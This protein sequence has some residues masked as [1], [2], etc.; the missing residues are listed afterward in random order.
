MNLTTFASRHRDQ[1]PLVVRVTKGYCGL[2]E[3][4]SISEGDTFNIHFVKHT[5]VMVVE[6]ENRSGRFS[7][8]MNS[9]V[10]FGV[11]Y[12]PNN[13]QR[14]AL[15]GFQFPKVSDL[16]SM[17][18]L[19]KIVCVKKAYN[20]SS[21]ESTVAVNEILVINKVR[22]TL[23]GKQLKVYSITKGRDK[24]L[25][26][27]CTGNFTTKPRDIK[28]FLTEILKYA[29]EDLPQK[30]IL[31]GNDDIPQHFPSK[32][33]STIVTLLHKT[34]EVSLV[35]TS[36]IEYDMQNSPLM[37]IPLSLDITVRV[38]ES[39]DAD[40]RQLQESSAYLY[41]RFDMSRLNPYL[42]RCN[43]NGSLE[44]QSLLYT[45][46]RNEYSQG[47]VELSTPKMESLYD[48]LGHEGGEQTTP[49]PTQPPLPD[50][51]SS[52]NSSTPASSGHYYFAKKSSS[53][54]QEIPTSASGYDTATATNPRPSKCGS[55]GGVVVGNSSRGAVPSRSM[56]V[57]TNESDYSY[58]TTDF[59]RGHVLPPKA[60]TGEDKEGG[61][62]DM[63]NSSGSDSV[64][65]LQ[66]VHSWVSEME[67]HILSSAASDSS[68]AAAATS[69]MSELKKKIE[70]L[71]LS[72]S[73][74]NAADNKASSRD[75]SHSASGHAYSSSTCSYG[76]ASGGNSGS[77]TSNS[78][79][80][81][82]GSGSVVHSAAASDHLRR[83]GAAYATGGSSSSNNIKM[84]ATTNACSMQQQPPLCETATLN[85]GG[86]GGGG[87]GGKEVSSS[88]VNNSTAVTTTRSV[89]DGTPH[90]QR[91][92]RQD[93]P[94]GDVS[95]D[96]TVAALSCG[97]GS[98]VEQPQSCAEPKGKRRS[99]AGSEE[100]CD[101]TAQQKNIE[102][103]N[104][105]STFE[106]CM[107][108]YVYVCVF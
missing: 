17:K 2:D 74:A 54:S 45:T 36:A 92:D 7:V 67:Q 98:R 85:R 1:L 90:P 78:S 21:A 12:N 37:D 91:D 94:G 42:H 32:L 71:S 101:L 49:T 108:M 48:T 31:F 106:V 87:G 70:N 6:Y 19:P 64:S 27:A 79:P 28:L 53:S 25:S 61:S 69:A 24:T 50:N 77:S 15:Q 63:N 18:T 43:S 14:E 51:N 60:K 4:S 81:N 23:R 3:E 58:V 40:L 13:N 38:V 96:A 41:S 107:Y 9:A 82:S 5:T 105:L 103:L 68:S 99:P 73:N 66:Q 95:K 56:S 44:T 97:G 83:G 10:P 26:E 47:Y 62:G 65:A 86:G 88:S 33:S 34:V 102:Y 22:K 16:L 11:I 72:S 104:T 100:E 93:K 46:V 76:S 57:P 29:S 30:A 8:P 89:S 35:A 55:S 39:V 75:H 84:T 80:A 59:I 20:G 52:N